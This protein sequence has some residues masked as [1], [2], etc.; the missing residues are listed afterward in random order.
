MMPPNRLLRAAM[1]CGLL[2]LGTGVGIFLLWLIARWDWLM[3][4]GLFT[5]YGGIVS[6]LV[7]LG[8]LVAAGKQTPSARPALG[9]LLANFPI[10]GFIIVVA[11]VIQTRFPV[12][13]VNEGHATLDQ[14]VVSGGGVEFDFGSVAPGQTVTRHRLIDHDGSLVFHARREGEEIEGTVEGY[15]TNNQ[16]GHKRVVFDEAGEFEVLDHGRD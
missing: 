6:V 13:V 7:G 2:P 15:V 3:M 14:F 16:G 11:F 8:F 1:I 5:V 4:A 9:I 12:T 10:A